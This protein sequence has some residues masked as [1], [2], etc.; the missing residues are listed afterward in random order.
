MQWLLLQARSQQNY[1]VVDDLYFYKRK[2]I[3]TFWIK[4]LTV[5]LNVLKH[6]FRTPREV[7]SFFLLT[8]QLNF[9]KKSLKFFKLLCSN[10]YYNVDSEEG[11]KKIVIFSHFW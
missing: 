4:V 3:I 10:I 5:L 7:G 6:Q 9:T 11:K 8:G 2:H 1:I